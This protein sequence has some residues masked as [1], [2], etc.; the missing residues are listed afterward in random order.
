M[1]FSLTVKAWLCFTW[2]D[3]RK[4]VE[5]RSVSC[6]PVTKSLASACIVWDSHLDQRINVSLIILLDFQDK[7]KKIEP[8]LIHNV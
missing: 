1:S 3:N 2:V 4:V 7:S 8:P 6:N 5:K